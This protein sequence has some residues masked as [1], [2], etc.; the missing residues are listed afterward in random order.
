MMKIVNFVA[1]AAG[2]EA[3]DSDH[4]SPLGRRGAVRQQQ[5][6]S[7][8]WESLDRQLRV[9][10]EGL[11]DGFRPAAVRVC[12][13]EWEMEQW[14][15]RDMCASTI[16]WYH[17]ARIQL[18]HHS[19]H[20]AAGLAS[21]TTPRSPSST[22]QPVSYAEIL[23]QSRIHAKEIVAIAQGRADEGTRIHSVQPLWTA[24]LVLGKDGD[25]DDDDD[26]GSAAA[27]ENGGEVSSGE[28]HAWRRTIVDLLRGIE[29]DMGWA[30]EYRVQNLLELWGIAPADWLPPVFDEL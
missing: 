15:P 5:H 20:A 11:P 7:Q 17:V 13:P 22:A 12:H 24:G 14:F 21:T 16:Q 8:Y 26:D 1:A 25:D 27:R 9:W 23:R 19:P 6:L 18:L 30:S 2:D 29:R 10:H 28:T 3:S 4:R